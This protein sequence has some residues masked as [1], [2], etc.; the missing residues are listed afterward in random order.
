MTEFNRNGPTYRI[1]S[2]ISRVSHASQV[3]AKIRFS[4]ADRHHYLK[5]R[6]YL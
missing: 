2:G 5:E 6:G 3:A 4:S 1:V